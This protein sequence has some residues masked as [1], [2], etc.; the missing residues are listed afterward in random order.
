[1]FYTLGVEGEEEGRNHLI[2]EY[3][4]R[5]NLIVK[6]ISLNKLKRRGREGRGR[7]GDLAHSLARF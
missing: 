2:V 1:M 3:E 6:L 7:S 5:L 4:V